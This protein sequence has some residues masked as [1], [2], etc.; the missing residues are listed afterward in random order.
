MPLTHLQ[1]EALAFWL[2]IAARRVISRAPGDST[3][4]SWKLF[5]ELLTHWAAGPVEPISTSDP[6]AGA[7]GLWAATVDCGQSTVDSK[8]TRSGIYTFEDPAD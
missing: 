8:L 3:V 5:L 2:P 6:G 4:M 1:K 7:S